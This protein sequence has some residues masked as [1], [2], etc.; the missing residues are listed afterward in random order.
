MRRSFSPK[1]DFDQAV[2]FSN[3]L[4]ALFKQLRK[5]GF[6]ARQSFSCCGSCAGYEIATK[7]K[8]MPEAKRAEVKGSVFYTKQDTPDVRNEA[9]VYI[10]Y[11]QIGVHEVGDF[12]LPS[13]EIGQRVAALARELGLD[14]D[15]NGEASQKIWLSLPEPQPVIADVR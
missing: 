12:G 13:L 11:G 5:E 4:T 10:A 9:G 15:W 14:V 6:I 3:K 1:V 7:V 2:A 8:E